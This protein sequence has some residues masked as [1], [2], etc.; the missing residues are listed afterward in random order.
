MIPSASTMVIQRTDWSWA[1]A[2]M[3]AWI[4][5]QSCCPSGAAAF[6]TAGSAA[7][8]ATKAAMEEPEASA[9]S[10]MAAC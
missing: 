6:S 10:S 8:L 5:D 1:A 2:A 4:G 7:L 9:I 3:K